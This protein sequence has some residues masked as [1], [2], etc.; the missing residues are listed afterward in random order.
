MTSSWQ[1][2][3]LST[4]LRHTLKRKL[5]RAQTPLDVRRALHAG[6]PFVAPR[7]VRFTAASV[8]QVPV[9]WVERK[10]G[11]NAT[12]LLF[13]H[14]GGYLACS[15]RSHR[16]FTSFFARHGMRVCAPDYRLA[17][18]HPFPAGLDDAEAVYRALLDDGVDPQRLVLAGDS[19]GGGLALSLLLRLRAA[20]APLPAAVALFSPLT[21]L[22]ATGAS[23]TSNS[24]RCAMFPGDRI[25]YASSFYLGGL[26]ARDPRVSPL[27]AD[28]AGLPPMLVHASE[29]EVL[30]DDATRLA[31]KARA[32]GVEVQLRLWRDVPHD[33]QLFH[34][35][36]P[37]GRDSLRLAC[38]FL[39]DRTMGG[40]PVGKA[41][42]DVAIVGAGF[43]GIGMAIKLKQAGGHS[44]V[45]LE[46][47]SDIGGTW[48]DNTY[49]GCAAD[50]PAHVYSYSFEQNPDWSRLY[51]QQP[52]ILAYLKRCV[53]K[54]DLR[55][56]IRYSAELQQAVYDE[57][58]G[59]WELRTAD[60]CTLRARVLVAATGALHHPAVPALPGIAQFQGAAFHS[61]QWRHEVDLRGKRVAVVGSG[62]SAAQFIPQ[63]APV[64]AQLTLF[65]RSAPWV[66]RKS[67]RAM[68]PWE[69]ALFKRVPGAL[70]LFRGALYW[71]QE[72]LGLGFLRPRL[73]NKVEHAARRRLQKRITD[74][75]LR[76]KLTPDY[77]IGCK[78]ILLANDYLP[79]L[80]RPNVRVV[81]AGI[82]R[83][84]AN[85]VVDA[86]GVAHGADV[87][88]YA[89][90]FKVSEAPGP[91]H[92]VGRDG[93]TL[94]QAWEHGRA[95]YLGLAVTGFPNL[96]L[97]LGPNSGLGHHSV[98]F[99]IEQQIGAVLR[100]LKALRHAGGAA[101]EVRPDVQRDYNAALQ[102]RIGK[103]VWASGCRSWY[104]NAAGR[105][106]V[107]WPGL[108]V[109]YWWRM[110]R[111][112]PND[113]LQAGG[114]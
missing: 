9:E 31:D 24:A 69:Q 107:L 14:G 100:C 102:R 37:E 52:E 114:G 61:A 91:L 45:V 25:A 85:G 20:G 96:F 47:A 103:T 66:L 80:A 62:A 65:Q 71:M 30:R 95:A 113:L 35:F 64:T 82:A 18:E 87:L 97:L 67:D 5:R 81:T 73:M 63:I 26:D 55:A 1:A 11:A 43:S 38:A 7:D 89:T 29:D 70:P 33:W 54:H 77:A 86:E 94:K 42:V 36:V 13:L 74:D 12:T 8:A 10:S 105:N 48:R 34:P 46:K 60:G 84:E 21:D 93:V 40:P 51:A 27:Y 75:A 90:G 112:R 44:F 76:Q 23:I 15:P 108:A 98:V 99:M 78:R 57:R 39:L 49:P 2:R 4:F 110:K 58:G 32:A 79:A 83:I 68:R 19:A 101:V 28:L 53:E 3:A 109:Q 72:T 56:H 6:P 16:P 22:A 92:I 50:V 59:C 41:D 111:L 104:Q 106:E 88:I 17:P